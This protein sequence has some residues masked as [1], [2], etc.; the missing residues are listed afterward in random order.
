[1]GPF[2]DPLLGPPEIL[3]HGRYLSRGGVSTTFS[4]ILPF[5]LFHSHSLACFLARSLPFA[6]LRSLIDDGDDDDDDDDDD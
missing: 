2:L 6:P 3:P 4:Q 1:M 5:I